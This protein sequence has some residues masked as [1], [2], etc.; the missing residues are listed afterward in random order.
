MSQ[1]QRNKYLKDQKKRLCMTGERVISNELECFGWM[2]K[3]DIH[4]Q[5][6]VLFINKNNCF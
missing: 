4:S 3:C 1:L 2:L 5:S 6:C